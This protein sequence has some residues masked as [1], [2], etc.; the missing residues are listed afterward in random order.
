MAEVWASLLALAPGR[1]VLAL[2]A[3]AL[4]FVAVAGQERAVVAHLALPVGRWRG[5]RAAAASAAVSQ[6]LGFGPVLGALVRRRLL[7]EVTLLQSLA[8]SA[9]ITLGFFVGLGL[10]VLALWAVVPGLAHR[11]L[12]AAGLAMALALLGA[13]A[14]AR[15]PEI[16]GL[17]K[18]NLFILGRFLAWLA[19]DLAALAT[20]FWAVLPQHLA[21]SL[22]EV[23]PI[24]LLA[25]GLGTASGSPGGLGAFEVAILAWLPGEGAEELLAGILAFRA[26]AY[27]LPALCGILWTLTAGRG[28]VVPEA[29]GTQEVQHLSSEAL[30]DLPEAEAQLI[31]QGQLRLLSLGGGGLWLSGQ[32]AHTR[33]M[34]GRPMG[35]SPGQMPADAQAILTAAET[36]ARLEARLLCLYKIDAR[37]A[38]AARARGH[39]VLPVAR[40]AVLE[41]GGFHLS[42]PERAGLRR[43][44]S[45]AR[46]A[47][48]MVE[49]CANPPLAE[50]E[51][52]AAAWSATHG[53]ERGFSMGKWDRLYASGQ[54]VFTARAAD[55]RLLAFVTFHAAR[56]RWVLDLVRFGPDAPDGTIYALI[57]AAL[58][59]AR[60]QEVQELSLAA[61][62]LRC[63][64][65]TGW[66]GALLRRCTAG[67]GQG[68]EQFKQCFAPRWRRLYIAAPG[69]LSLIFGG[70]EL[71]RAILRPAPLA[72]GRRR[73]VVFSG[74]LG[75]AR[76]AALIDAARGR[77]SGRS[78]ASQDDAGEV[79][80]PKIGVAAKTRGRAA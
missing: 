57:V 70:L 42:G 18:P 66:R 80:A 60:W 45:H 24:F 8:V 39:A 7:P 1:I 47:G 27:L 75:W 19:L 59:A 43:K 68:L 69:P 76:G 71:T 14:L 58:G 52:V 41:P 50:M 36:V 79:S 44:L 64:G 13:L 25:L 29:L 74:R 26:L 34:L 48:V 32:L 63:L 15:Q 53:Q 31:R 5:A 3:V 51:A 35:G 72:Q 6:T 21:P 46:K 65:L 78:A 16:I 55:G 4:A 73:L 9:G 12:S 30:A 67:E 54:R 28:A 38:L 49:D 61:V 20:A 62:P 23:L 2:G 56:R 17:R 22:I 37:T 40:E 10:F 77:I 33:V 11:G